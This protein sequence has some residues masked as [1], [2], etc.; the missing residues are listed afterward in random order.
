LNG[1]TV[2]EN[3]EK[4][5]ATKLERRKMSSWELPRR[6]VNVQGYSYFGRVNSIGG[7]KLRKKIMVLGY[8]HNIQSSFGV[9]TKVLSSIRS[10][11][12]SSYKQK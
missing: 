7:I 12:T 4:I 10:W 5:S 6:S 2:V 8:N 1:Q 9:T 11:I 3:F